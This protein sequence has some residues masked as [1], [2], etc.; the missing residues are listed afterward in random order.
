LNLLMLSAQTPFLQ[1]AAD[2]ELAP[3]ERD[4]ARAELAR[5]FMH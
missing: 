3:Q 4:K 5:K 1:A 2:K